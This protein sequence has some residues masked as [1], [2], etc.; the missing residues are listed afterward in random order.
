M[1]L[2]W[3]AM[4]IPPVQS[5]VGAVGLFR[6]GLE[7]WGRPTILAA[8]PALPGTCGFSRLG[9]KH[10]HPQAVG[11]LAGRESQTVLQEDVSQKCLVPFG[12]GRP[13]LLASW[14]C[15]TTRFFSCNTISCGHR[16]NPASNSH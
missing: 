7:G 13:V 2:G 16:K 9:V 10:V 15:C 11:P 4:G 6:R 3:D 1:F 5:P 14:K 8:V 12:H